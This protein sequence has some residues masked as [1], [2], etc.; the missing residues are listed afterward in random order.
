M[1]VYV[2]TEGEYSDYNIVAVRLDRNEA[3]DICASLNDEETEYINF[4][5]IEEYDTEDIQIRSIKK[6]NYVYKMCLSYKSSEIEWILGPGYSFKKINKIS[7]FIND[8]CKFINITA[9]FP[10]GIT[11]E[12]A[13]KIML[14]RVAKFKAERAGI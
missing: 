9:T 14:D 5:Q 3:E 7:V 13:K 12:K 8:H 6:P 10:N 11:E 2:I 4:Y 1:K